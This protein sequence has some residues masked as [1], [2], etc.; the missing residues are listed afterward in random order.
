MNYKCLKK[1]LLM[2]IYVPKVDEERRES[3]Y[4]VTGEYVIYTAHMI[5]LG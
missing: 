1:K 4:Y 3:V 2:K 5:L